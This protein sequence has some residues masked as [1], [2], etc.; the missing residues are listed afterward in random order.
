MEKHP[1]EILSPEDL[2]GEEWA[3]VYGWDGMYQASNLGR[4]KSLPRYV[5]T[6][7]AHRLTRLRILKQTIDSKSVA[8]VDLSTSSSVTTRSVACIVFEAFNK[9]PTEEGKIIA[10]K[11]KLAYDNRISNLS[12]MSFG[13]SN[14]LNYDLG[15]STYRS[16]GAHR[17]AEADELDRTLF[18]SD[19]TRICRVCKR[20]LPNNVF[21]VASKVR[22]LRTC[23]DCRLIKR[24]IVN[25]GKQRTADK[26]FAAGL[27]RCNPCGRTLPLT[28]FGPCKSSFGGRDNTCRVCRREK[29]R[30]RRANNQNN[31]LHK[32]QQ[33]V[34]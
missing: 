29:H 19:A 30:K 14:K 33:R 28:D 15:V 2:P 6:G 27:R 24:G 13:Q 16:I 7:N 9:R 1:H 17:A 10:H 3:D 22:P 32:E 25:V 4:V 18:V 21:Y 11:N 5:R 34:P 26:L 31:E 20:E 12:E 23:V 8:R